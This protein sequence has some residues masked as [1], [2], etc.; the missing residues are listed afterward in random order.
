MNRDQEKAMKN[1]RI[2]DLSH[3]I[4]P[5]K[6]EYRLEIDTRFTEQW[7]Q[8][9]QY[10]RE[11]GH[12]YV[13]S[14]VTFSTHVGTHIEF[15]YHHVQTGLDAARFPLEKLVGEA[16][17]IDISAWGQN[18]CITLGDL[19]EVAKSRIRPGDIVFC[20]TGFD[21]YYHTDKQHYRPWFTTDAIQ[22]LV[23]SSLHVV[24]VDTS[25]IEIRNPDGSPSYGQPNHETLLGAGIP[26]VEYLANLG[27][28]VNKRFMAYILPVKLAGAEAFPVRV[29]GVVEEE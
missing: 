8:F 6:E 12:W 19:Q 2:V 26:L 17:V 28:L 22:W 27:E 15:P 25:G 3:T 7:E 18:D 5:G 14:E 9:A 10:K 24:G 29:I 1:Y 4:L 21:R 11:P 16:T 23:D 13:L 20:Y